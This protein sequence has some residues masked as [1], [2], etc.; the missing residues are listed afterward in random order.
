MESQTEAVRARADAGAETEDPPRGRRPRPSFLTFEAYAL[1]LAWIAVLVLFSLLKPDTFA[2]SSNFS[3]I[4]GSQAV[5][6]LLALGALIP[7]TTGDF[8]LSIASTLGISSVVTAVLSAQHGWP[9]LLA[10]LAALGVALLIGVINGALVAWLGLDSFIVTLGTGTFLGGMAQWISNSNIISGVPQVLSDWTIG[11]SFLGVAV[12]FW[13]G[14]A[15]VLVLWYVFEFTPL[16]RRLLF[17]GR[18]RGVAQMSGLSVLRLRWGALVTSAL[19]AGVAG[20]VYAGE[21]GAADPTSGLTFLL[22]AFAAAFLGATAILPGRFN[23]PGTF[24][25]VY[26]L[27]SGITG[28]QQLGAESFVQQLF[29][30]G[31]LVIAVGLSHVAR[32]RRAHAKGRRAAA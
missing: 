23:A 20:V 16:G 8:D 14:V 18:S 22:P 25:A 32:N 7:L 10:I 1:V 24:V 4:F 11:N 3:T 5:L 15:A 17:V 19:I 12:D 21:L 9:P 13:Y 6:A 31:A 2:T 27:M 28:L 26:F 29:Y 30:G